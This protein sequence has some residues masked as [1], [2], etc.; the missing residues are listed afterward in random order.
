MLNVKMGGTLTQHL[1]NAAAP[2]VV[3]EPG[4]RWAEIAG[5]ATW[6]LNSWHHI[7]IRRLSEE[8]ALF[9]RDAV[10]SGEPAICSGI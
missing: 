7:A 1:E 8:L 5:C 2:E 4:T 9:A 3:I 10:A 6:R